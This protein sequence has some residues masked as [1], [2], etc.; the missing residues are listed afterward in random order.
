MITQIIYPE[1][2]SYLFHKPRSLTKV[3]CRWR[4]HPDGVVWQ[5]IGGLEPDMRCKICGDDLG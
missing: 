4:L 3:I 2:W 5:N 1:F